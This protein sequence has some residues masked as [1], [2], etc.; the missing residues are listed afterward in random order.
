MEID[1]NDIDF[2]KLR[3]DLIDYF[4]TFSLIIPFAMSE[5]I[6]IEN[7]SD[8]ELL[9]IINKTNLNIIDYI[10][11]ESLKKVMHYE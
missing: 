3:A 11:G 5:V 10:H 7:A 1:I 2:T 8:I 6:N 9:N 4:G